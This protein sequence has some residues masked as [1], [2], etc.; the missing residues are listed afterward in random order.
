MLNCT[1]CNCC[2]FVLLS[3]I[4]DRE[5]PVKIDG[6]TRV[7]VYQHEMKVHEHELIVDQHEMKV[8]EHELIVYQHEMKVYEHEL[9]FISM[10]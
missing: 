10:R 2:T 5:E 4:G 1:Y 8:H 3:V 9:L 7:I 6:M